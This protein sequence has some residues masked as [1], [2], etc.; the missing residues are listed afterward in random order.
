M[1]RVCTLKP[2]DVVNGTYEAL[3]F[4]GS[5][6]SGDVPTGQAQDA[7]SGSACNATEQ[8]SPN[9]PANAYI[10][11]KARGLSPQACSFACGEVGAACGSVAGHPFKLG[12]GT[13]VL[14]YCKN[15]G[16]SF[17]CTYTFPSGEGCVAIYV[18]PLGVRWFCLPPG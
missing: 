1:E 18:S 11:C 17:T 10:N 5:G 3:R 15:G 4:L 9:M 16:P 6:P 12:Q 7:L 2:G 14:T 13:G 8:D